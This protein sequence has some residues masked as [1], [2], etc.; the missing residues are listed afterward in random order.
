[1]ANRQLWPHHNY[2]GERASRRSCQW[3][4][5]R[6]PSTSQFTSTATGVMCFSVWTLRRVWAAISSP[7]GASVWL[8]RKDCVC[9]T[10]SRKSDIMHA[11]SILVKSWTKAIQQAVSSKSSSAKHLHSSP[12]GLFSGLSSEPPLRTHA[13]GYRIIFRFRFDL[14]GEWR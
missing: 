9:S 10:V 7:N 2:A 11:S 12:F 5:K 4:G 3:R 14:D 13:A 6:G 1:M 8:L